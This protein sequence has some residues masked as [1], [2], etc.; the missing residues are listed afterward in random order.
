MKKS[1]FCHPF[2]L[3]ITHFLLFVIH[4]LLFITHFYFLSLIFLDH[5][6]INFETHETLRTLI[7]VIFG[8]LWVIFRPLK[9]R[10]WKRKSHVRVK[11][12][13]IFATYNFFS[14]LEGLFGP[15]AIALGPKRPFQ[16]FEKIMRDKKNYFFFIEQIVFILF[17]HVIFF[18]F[19]DFLRARKWPTKSEKRQKLR[20]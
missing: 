12:K 8:T 6:I 7:F 15:R 19:N 1:T 11:K 20:S 5:K 4:F 14:W 13:V 17:E 2:S 18:F 16:S 9:S 10:F 3:F